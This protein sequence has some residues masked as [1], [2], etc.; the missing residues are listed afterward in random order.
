M[1]LLSVCLSYLHL[2]P[3]NLPFT[4]I[5]IHITLCA[6]VQFLVSK[7]AFKVSCQDASPNKEPEEGDQVGQ[8]KKTQRIDH[9]RVRED[10][11]GLTF[12]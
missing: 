12:G 8:C 4:I 10:R 7:I 5:D 3:S 1:W 9:E 6:L 11:R 2:E